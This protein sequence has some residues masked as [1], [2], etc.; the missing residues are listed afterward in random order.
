LVL[1]LSFGIGNDSEGTA[2]IDSIVDAFALQHPDILFVISAA[3]DGPGI[4]TVGF[5]GSAEFALTVCALFP[6]V[7]AEPPQPGVRPPDDVIGWWS[8]RGGELQKPDLCAPGVAFSNV[9]PWQAGEE[10]SGGTSMAAPQLSGAAALLLS[11]LAQLNQSVR[12]VDVRRALTS[13]ASPIRGATVIDMGAGVPNVEEA[14]RWLRAAHRA[15]RFSIRALTDDAGT[16]RTTAA[17][18]R[19]GLTPGDTIQRFR[20]VP[21]DGQPF[22]RVLLRSDAPWLS[23]PDAIDFQGEPATVE[24]RYDAAQ[25]QGP[26]VYVGTVWA[27]PETDSLAGAAFGLTNTV[28]VPR[29]LETQFSDR[30]YLA[31]GQTYRYFFEVPAEAG[32]L[33]LDLVVADPEREATLY[34]FEPSGQPYRGEPSVAAGGDAPERSGIAV[35]AEDMLGGVYEAVVVSPPLSGVTYQFHVSLPE[36]AVTEI[37]ESGVTVQHRHGGDA[38]TEVTATVIGA[39]QEQRLWGRGA[40]PETIATIAPEWA[41]ELQL[42]I[43]VSEK[44]W[45]LVTDFAVTVWDT[46]GQLVSQG[47]LNY[48]TARQRLKLD[49]VTTRALRVELTPAFALPDPVVDWHADVR[50]TFVTGE[51]LGVMIAASA[52]HALLSSGGTTLIHGVVPDSIAGIPE[53]YHA[54]IEA[55]TVVRG[56]IRSVRRAAVTEPGRTN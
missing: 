10:I 49:S 30:R 27:R 16:G 29:Q 17:F 42:D 7:F 1:N 26:G 56:Q 23:A 18:R 5:P 48:R 9:P 52:S 39:T 47:P 55:K 44:T 4:S 37:G 38:R 14:F 51:P 6:G 33:N 46:T 32:G 21:V 31:S 20:V 50:I 3:N 12:A 45:P 40:V 41:D 15:G 53:G 43:T 13:T 35:R 19:N 28:V 24:V 8:G 36:V 11:G 2:S 22:A 54:L 34:L 25:L